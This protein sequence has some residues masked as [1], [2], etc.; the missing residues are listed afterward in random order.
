NE[1]NKQ[2][3][4]EVQ[5]KQSKIQKILIAVVA[6]LLF[7]LTI[8][9]I[10]YFLGF[11][12]PEEPEENKKDNTV[13][14]KIEKK[15]NIDSI[16]LNKDRLNKKLQMLTKHEIISNEELEY[17]EN[18]IKEAEE[19]KKREAEEQ[20]K[21]EAEE[22]KKKEAD[23]ITEEYK[24]IEEEKNILLE[25]QRALLKQ[26]ENFLKEQEKI[27]IELEAKRIE[28]FNEIENSRS[29]KKNL[30]K[31]EDVKNT[32]IIENEDIITENTFL[33]F[34]NI[35]TIQGDLYKSYL[36]DIQVIDKNIALCRDS[37]NRIEIISGPY[38]SIKKRNKILNKLIN[39]GFKEAYFVDFTKEEYMKRC[40]Y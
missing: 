33:N 20:K 14:K 37:R 39:N 3:P 36:D 5:K 40:K 7:I 23:K 19:Q 32:T 22:Q 17:Q 28:L 34:I 12:D 21:R 25:N 24:K 30:I 38:K 18:K 9:T 35:A 31:K 27:N 11:F 13:I 1:D 4:S 10:L 29:T 8:G 26:Q 15:V 6:F 2:E 16:T